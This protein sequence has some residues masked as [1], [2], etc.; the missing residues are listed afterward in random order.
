MGDN[1]PKRMGRP[2]KSV[3]EAVLT[4]DF[5]FLMTPEMKA[6]VL[7]HGGAYLIRRLIAEEQTRQE[8]GEASH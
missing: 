4:A 1:T 3:S 5:R 8:A 2:P 6:W 7:S